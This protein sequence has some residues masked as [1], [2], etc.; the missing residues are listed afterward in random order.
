MVAVNNLSGLTVDKVFIKKIAEVVLQGEKKISQDISI[1][2]V[3]ADKMKALNQQYRRKNR[4]TDVLTFP[5]LDI[6]ICPKVVKE[7]AKSA[8]STFKAELARVVIH[9]ILHFLD[10]D[11]ETGEKEAEEMRNK[12]ERYYKMTN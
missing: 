2:L 4:P 12:E 6:V 3:D 7:N 9:G 11:H 8:Q 10:Y 1:V 5:E